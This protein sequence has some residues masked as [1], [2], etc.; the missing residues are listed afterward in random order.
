MPK[1][2]STPRRH[3][4]KPARATRRRAPPSPE[5]VDPEPANPVPILNE[6]TDVQRV[7]AQL[8]DGGTLVN[9]LRPGGEQTIGLQRATGGGRI[10]NDLRLGGR[11]RIER[12]EATGGGSVTF[13]F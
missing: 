10:V 9:A 13:E 3:V 11:Q 12:V 8:V 5:P 4:A 7:A 6:V 2:K 1:R